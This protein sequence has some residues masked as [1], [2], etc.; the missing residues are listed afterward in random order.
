MEVTA[1]CGTATSSQAAAAT[2]SGTHVA[3][4]VA[5]GEESE[6]EKCRRRNLEALYGSAEHVSLC[7]CSVFA[8]AIIAF[9]SGIEKSYGPVAYKCR[10]GDR[11]LI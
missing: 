1:G 2:L 11:G 10:V 8:A 6:R 3:G 4:V 5:G 9:S 7:L